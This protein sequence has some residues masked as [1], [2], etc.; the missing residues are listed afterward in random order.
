MFDRRI[1][2]CGA[3]LL[4]HG[5]PVSSAHA[6]LA[7]LESFAA[8]GKMNTAPQQDVLPLGG[9]SLAVRYAA[10]NPVTRR[11]FDAVL[12]EADLAARAGM[13]LI[14]GRAGKQDAATIAAARFLGKA[15]SASLRKLDNLLQPQAA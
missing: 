5:D 9:P 12:R 10:A 13:G 1:S 11:R 4:D 7:T 3:S 15:V 2:T 14:L 6:L 8:A